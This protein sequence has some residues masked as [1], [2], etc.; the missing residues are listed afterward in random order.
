MLRGLCV[1]RHGVRIMCHDVGH[2]LD[3]GLRHWDIVYGR[4]GSTRCMHGELQCMRWFADKLHFLRVWVQSRQRALRW[5]CFL[6]RAE[7]AVRCRHKRSDVDLGRRLLGS[8]IP[9]PPCVPE[10]THH[11][12]FCQHRQRLIHA[13]AA[14]DGVPLSAEP[15]DSGRSHRVV[16]RGEPGRLLGAR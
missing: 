3:N 13:F 7:H 15:L 12:D 14:D 6:E 8:S 10:R 16:A 4:V 1:D 9:K 2:L 11:D 5:S